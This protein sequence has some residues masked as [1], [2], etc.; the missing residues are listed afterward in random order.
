MCSAA[1]E[2][3]PEVAVY[4]GNRAAA[5]IMLGKYKQALE[6]GQISVRLDPGYIRGYQRAG[7]ALLTLG[8]TAEVSPVSGGLPA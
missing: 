1:I 7:K 8:R 3:D 2:L 5:S 6:D 4:Y